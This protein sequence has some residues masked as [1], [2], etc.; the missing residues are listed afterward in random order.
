M[1]VECVCGLCMV[2][3]CVIYMK[4]CMECILCLHGICLWRIVHE[5]LCVVVWCVYWK[6]MEERREE[7]P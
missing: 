4:V 6:G 1:Y 5:C 7:K 2:Y 3:L